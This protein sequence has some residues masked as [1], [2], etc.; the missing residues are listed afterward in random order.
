MNEYVFSM[1]SGKD[2]SKILGG[3]VES[4][5]INPKLMT[6]PSR[7]Y[8]LDEGEM[9]VAGNSYYVEYE[10]NRYIVGEQG[11][12]KA[13]NTSDKAVLL[14][15]LCIYALICQY[16]EPNV[17][18]TDVSIVLAC[19]L[20]LLKSKEYKERFKN[21]IGNDGED[22]EIVVGKNNYYFRIKDITLKAEGSGVL[23]LDKDKFKNK[24]C[25]IIDIG[26]LNLQGS[27]YINGVS[28]VDVRFTEMYGSN[29]LN[30]IVRERLEIFRKGKRV[31]ISQVE[32]A[33]RS[34][35]LT[36]ADGKE[37]IE[38]AIK[39]YIRKYV[40][41]PIIDRG[42][43]LETVLPIVIGGTVLGI[44]NEIEEVIPNAEIVGEPQMA[45]LKGLYKIAFAKYCRR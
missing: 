41:R 12:E 17:R 43:D 30:S 28:Q 21:Y 2:L 35:S 40:V 15:K 10:G 24:Q 29:V 36:G 31:T 5:N 26:G 14:H 13:I 1:D 8:N 42:I 9:D 44:K 32:S 23:Y 38:K 37:V 11:D 39:N 19:P 33:I 20:N 7:L 45:S 18:D 6:L 34:R 3:K 27:L 25:L 4:G 16:I 22:I